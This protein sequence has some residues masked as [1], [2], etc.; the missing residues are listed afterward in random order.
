[1]NMDI[2]AKNNSPMNEAVNFTTIISHQFQ[3]YIV[4]NEKF[5]IF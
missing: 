5:I 1:M 2:D 4:N 3:I